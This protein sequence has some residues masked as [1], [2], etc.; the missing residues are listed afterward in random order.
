MPAPHEPMQLQ[1][2]PRMDRG[3]LE[4]RSPRKYSMLSRVSLLSKLSAIKPIDFVLEQEKKSSRNE[5]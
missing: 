3:G 5:K 4:N 1:E 2:W